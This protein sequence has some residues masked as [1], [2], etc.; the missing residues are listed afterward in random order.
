MEKV[1]KYKPKI[2]RLFWII[3]SIVTII[4]VPCTIIALSDWV[5]GIILILTDIF[6]YY[7]MITSLVAYVELRENTMYV[8][9]GFILKREI[10]YEKI[11]KIEKEKKVMSYSMLSIKNSYEHYNI[12]YN[13]YD[14]ITVSVV[15]NEDLIKELKLRN[16]NIK[17]I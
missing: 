11:I 1:K 9:F 15:D 17:G 3:W 12:R 16:N 7:F 13:K 5:S 10:P 14:M 2:D 6:T 4:L 8:K